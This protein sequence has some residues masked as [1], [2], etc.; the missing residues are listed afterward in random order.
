[1]TV[2]VV[3]QL[4]GGC[5]QLAEGWLRLVNVQAPATERSVVFH[6]QRDNWFGLAWKGMG[7]S[8]AVVHRCAS[9]MLSR[10]SLVNIT[11]SKSRLCIVQVK[12][13]SSLPEKAF[14]SL[15]RCIVCLFLW[16]VLRVV[17][18]NPI[19]CDWDWFW[20]KFLL[21]TSYHWHSSFLLL[22]FDA[23][24]CQLSYFCKF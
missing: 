20:L 12:W 14:D 15:R 23:T 9:S 3:V 2:P 18:C 5:V 21:Y 11:C 7:Q 16:P 13:G 19:D 22:L 10:Q 17:G 8:T 6:Q 4:V 1:M 24:F